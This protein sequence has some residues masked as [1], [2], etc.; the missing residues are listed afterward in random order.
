MDSI[1]GKTILKIEFFMPMTA[2]KSDTIEI[3]YPRKQVRLVSG[4]GKVKAVTPFTL[5]ELEGG[6]SATAGT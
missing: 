3:D 1:S 5:W 6:E 4:A 2:A